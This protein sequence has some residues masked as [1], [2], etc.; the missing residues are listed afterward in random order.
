[1]GKLKSGLLAGVML[2]AAAAAWSA[3]AE[4]KTVAALYQERAQLAGHTVAVK[5]RV[6]RVNNNILHRNFLHVQ[7]GTAGKGKDSDQVTVTSQ[8]TAEVG[9]Q[10]LVTGTLA[11]NRDFGSG[12]TY[13]VIIEKASIKK[14]Q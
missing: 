11:V 14:V 1:M 2:T 7:D 9:D 4:H 10:V 3:S 13:P 5:G 12:Y 8:D 6:T